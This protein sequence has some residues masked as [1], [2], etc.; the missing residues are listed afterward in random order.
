MVVC[1]T[2]ARFNMYADILRQTGPQGPNDPT[3]SAGEWENRQDPDTGEII[4]VW[5]PAEDDP[6]TVEN[7]VEM[8]TFPCMAR[9][10]VDGGIRVAGTT[11]RWDEVY[12]G[13]DF[14]R[15]IFPA[16]VQMTRRDR[17]T[18]IRDRD[19][20]VIWREEEAFD[21]DGNHPPTIFS[22]N[23]ITPMPDPFG[24]HYESVALLERVSTQ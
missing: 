11:E 23:G 17:I 4:R 15:M 10:I 13:V 18:N 8:A 22:V 20:N 24:K 1:L 12:V 6:D 9:G 7:E 14:V 5:V 16:H 21:E 3:A 2:S 19:G